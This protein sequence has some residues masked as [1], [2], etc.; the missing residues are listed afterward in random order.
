MRLIASYKS[1]TARIFSLARNP[2]GHW[3]V[4][5]QSAKIDVVSDPLQCFI[6]HSH[7]G[8]LLNATR[9]QFAG[10]MDSSTPG[11][12]SLLIVVGKKGAKTYLGVTGDRVGKAEWH[13][14]GGPVKAAQV[15]EKSGTNFSQ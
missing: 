4:E 9:Q 1:G 5:Q 7:T 13:S 12:N 3:E 11:P 2:S 8:K 6:I 14:T 10:L 15:V